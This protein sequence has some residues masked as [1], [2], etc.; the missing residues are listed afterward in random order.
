MRRWRLM[1]VF[2]FVLQLAA[3]AIVTGSIVAFVLI[4][5]FSL[6]DWWETR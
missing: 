5:F 1:D 2:H 3:M 6:L 4:G